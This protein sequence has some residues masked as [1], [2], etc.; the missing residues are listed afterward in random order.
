MS[1]HHKEYPV[2]MTPEGH[3]RRIRIDLATPAE[4][5]IR[6]AMT[7]VEKAGAHPRLTDAVILLQQALDAVAD[8]VDESL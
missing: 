7:E 3:P 6:N 4:A 5:A 2:K 8:F 1:E